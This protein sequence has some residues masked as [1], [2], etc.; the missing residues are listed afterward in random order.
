MLARKS[1][2]TLI[3]VRKEITI[4]MIHQIYYYMG[5]VDYTYI[6]FMRL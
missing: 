1:V 4:A 6:C 2:K 5:K 3:A